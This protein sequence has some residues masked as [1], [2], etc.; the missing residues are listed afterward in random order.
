MQ[1]KTLT[2]AGEGIFQGIKNFTTKTL[3]SFQFLGSSLPRDGRWTGKHHAGVYK[4]PATHIPHSA[5]KNVAATPLPE[6]L[7]D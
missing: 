6:R 3:L 2:K 4:K 7:L 5:D 1:M